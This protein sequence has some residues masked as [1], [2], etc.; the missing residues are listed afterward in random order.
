MKRPNILHLFADQMRFDAITSLGH[1]IVRTPALDRLR[2]R[3]TVFTNAFSPSPVC[4]SAR[5]S[6]IFGQYPHNTGCRCNEPMPIDGA[7]E[8]FMA[9]LTRAGYRTH[10]VGKCHLHPRP[11]DLWGFESR[12]TQEEIPP[13][14]E[15]D[16]YLAY[17]REVG[18]GWIGEPHGCRGE[19]YYIPQTSPLPPEHHPS[20]WV[21]DRTLDFLES[22]I[23]SDRPWYLFSSFIHPHPPFAPP[24]PWHKLYRAALMDLPNLPPRSETLQTWINRFQNRY[25]YRDQGYDLNLVR[26]IRAYYYGCVSFLDHQ[27]GRILARLGE[28]GELDNTLI[29]F[30]AD[31]GEYLGDYYC[32]GKRGMH[33][34]SARIPMMASLTERFPE[35]GLS[36][37]PASLVD[38]A[39]TFL[40][41]SGTSCQTHAH[42]GIDLAELAAGRA[43]RTT[44]YSEYARPF[45]PGFFPSAPPEEPGSDEPRRYATA[46][47]MAVTKDWKYIY[48]VADR[49]ESLFDRRQDP[50]ETRDVAPHP[51]RQ[52][53][54]RTLRKRLIGFL[55]DGGETGAIDAG[56]WK[57]LP[58]PSLPE[59]PDEGLLIQDMPWEDE[60]SGEY[61]TECQDLQVV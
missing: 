11:Y 34:V 53:V 40:A 20:Q 10:G 12:D 19:G 13:T 33:D 55:A 22:M 32:F 27:V 50:Q 14:P 42:D 45:G 16:D 23:G 57:T 8:T 2:K 38:I 31:H 17:L 26:M 47:Y 54:C 41:A 7:R 9:S 6:M 21:G 37:Q 35:G 49:R 36:E 39:P 15:R 51:L 58:Q 43:E 46:T 48:S 56:A 61:R 5:C 3:S 28:M 44:V 4:V 18:L 52:K 29:L 60:V 30:T 25:K 24:A 59:N 1:P